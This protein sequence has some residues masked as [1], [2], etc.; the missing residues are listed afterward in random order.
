[1]LKHFDTLT[2]FELPGFASKEVC[3]PGGAVNHCYNNTK[4]TRNHFLPLVTFITLRDSNF[5]NMWQPRRPPRRISPYLMTTS[6]NL[7]AALRV[8][9]KEMMSRSSRPRNV[10]VQSGETAALSSSSPALS[11]LTKC[12]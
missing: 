9:L 4:R 10:C 7:I 12:D 3:V 5:R 11:S 1:M 2:V 8:G 6:E